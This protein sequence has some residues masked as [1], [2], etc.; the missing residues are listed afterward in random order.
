MVASNEHYSSMMRRDGGAEPELDDEKPSPASLRFGRPLPKLDGHSAAR[1]GDTPNTSNPLHSADARPSLSTETDHTDDEDDDEDRDQQSESDNEGGGAFS[2]V[3]FLASSAL[4]ASFDGAVALVNA[5]FANLDVAN[6]DMKD[7]A[8]TTNPSSAAESDGSIEYDD[9]TDG[10]D[11]PDDDDDDAWRAARRLAW[12]IAIRRRV[13]HEFEEHYYWVSARSLSVSL[14]VD[15][16][17]WVSAS[18]AFD[19]A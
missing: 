11:E 8:P 1:E 13:Q 9:P 14:W 5:G 18:V 10:N 7:D 6:E 3:H 2:H 16:S 4:A 15:V 17:L 19:M 12:A